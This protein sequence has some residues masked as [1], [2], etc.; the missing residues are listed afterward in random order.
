MAQRVY[1]IAGE[2]SGD[3]HGAGLMSALLE[4]DPGITFSGL[5]GAAMNALS[6]EVRNWTGEAAVVGFWE[7]IKKYRYFKVQFELALQALEDFSPDILVLVDYPGFNLRLAAEVR[8]RGLDIRIIQYISPQVWAWKRGR[9]SRMARILDR[10]L[11]L[12][13]F[14]VEL[15]RGSGL[16]AQFVGHPVAEQ[17]A[18]LR[19]KNRRDEQLVAL[20]PGSRQREI[21]KNFPVMLGAAV[22]MIKIQPG[23]RFVSAAPGEQL[24]GRMRAMA[25]EQGVDCSVGVG[26]AH[27]LMTTACC[28]AV[29]S[30]TATLEAAFLGL[31]YCIV[32]RVSWPTYYLARALMAVDYLGMANLLAGRELVREFLQGDAVASTVAAELLRLSQSREERDALAAELQEVTA[33]LAESG[34][35]QRAAAAALEEGL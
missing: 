14:E 26:N 27:E 5:G 28:A 6:G 8:K 16:D 9:I 32:Y 10:M 20:L 24:A 15:Y 18:S 3:A 22:E 30:G 34:A 35:Y 33:P 13:P 7:V 17:L 29:A 4:Q 12:F 23:L 31:P 2:A 1:I 21:E 11:C 25:S 19:G